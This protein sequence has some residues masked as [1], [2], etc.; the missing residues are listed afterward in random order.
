MN[1]KELAAK[2]QTGVNY[3][4]ERLSISIPQF[5]EFSNIDRSRLESFMTG[6]GSLDGSDC[7]KLQDVFH[8]LVTHGEDVDA[9]EAQYRGFKQTTLRDKL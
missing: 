5:A 9:L 7:L 8:D 4:C 6:V 3:F 1:D 2:I